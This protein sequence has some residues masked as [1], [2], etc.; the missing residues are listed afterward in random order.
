MFG[1]ADFPMAGNSL[2]QALGASVGVDG[3][4]LRCEI[5]RHLKQEVWLQGEF[6][7]EGSSTSEELARAVSGSSWGCRSVLAAFSHLKR[8]R[9]MLHTS[10]V[11]D[12]SIMEVSD[13]SHRSLHLQSMDALV[14]VMYDGCSEYKGFVSLGCVVGF[15][16]RA[17]RAC[18][19]S[20]VHR[21]DTGGFKESV[22]D[23]ESSDLSG[24]NGRLE[25]LKMVLP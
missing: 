24:L 5:F 4:S 13:V 7:R 22:D 21:L 16:K 17:W 20:V 19:V 9:V 23:M 11:E 3:D 8:L 12:P 10:S 6:A 25:G 2:F 1:I 15:S 14:H 18:D